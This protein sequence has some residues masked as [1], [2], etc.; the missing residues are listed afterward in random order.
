[1]R[2]ARCARKIVSSECWKLL[3][4][5][6]VVRGTTGWTNLFAARCGAVVA[7]IVAVLAAAPS[8]AA[9][10]PG[11]DESR[12]FVEQL[13]DGAVRTWAM[14]ESDAPA[15]AKAMDALIRSTFD[16]DFI[17]RAVLGRYWR[18]LDDAERRRFREL[19]PEF[20]VEVY[21]PH[22]AKYSRDH[23]R[24]LG[25]RPRGKRDVVVKSELLSEQGAWVDADWRIR[26]VG[27]RIRIIDLSV[28]GVS[29]LL[30]QRQE[31]EAVIRR[32]GFA[33]FV[34]QLIERKNRAANARG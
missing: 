17:S 1:M 29:L 4:G 23:L 9:D 25:A 7:A 12:A 16:V 15:R 21:L 33:S 19:F 20:V 10:R 13:A 22:I 24:V 3:T 27:D 34:E 32:D 14:H 31:F 8:Q 2:A 28:A 26:S 11:L 5:G 6:C 18:G 30:V